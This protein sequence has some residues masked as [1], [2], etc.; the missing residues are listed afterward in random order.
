M[1]WNKIA[2]FEVA[3]RLGVRIESI[4]STGE[5]AGRWEI[6]VFDRLLIIEDDNPEIAGA[7]LMAYAEGVKAGARR[8]PLSDGA[9]RR[10]DKEMSDAVAPLRRS[11]T[12]RPLGPGG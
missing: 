8:W 12:K 6:Q 7:I 3:N 9:F 4:P 1:P 2:V 11:K 10:V 5:E